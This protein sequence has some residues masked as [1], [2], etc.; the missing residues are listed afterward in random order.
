MKGEKS[1]KV[2]E[3]ESFLRLFQWRLCPLEAAQMLSEIQP[4][5]ACL[6]PAY[7]T[8]NQM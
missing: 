4:H 6:C 7:F 3:L 8:N 2:K 5:L 1:T